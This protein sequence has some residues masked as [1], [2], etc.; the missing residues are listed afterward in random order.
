MHYPPPRQMQVEDVGHKAGPLL[1]SLAFS[2]RPILRR[3]DMALTSLGNACSTGIS[4]IRHCRLVGLWS[5][6]GLAFSGI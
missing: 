6:L 3:A 1:S 4:E 2:C 5:V